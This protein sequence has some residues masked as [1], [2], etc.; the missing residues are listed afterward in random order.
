[1][2]PEPL[3]KVLRDGGITVSAEELLDVL[4]LAQRLPPS[5]AAPLARAARNAA[6][7]THAAT[8][9][10]K[11]DEGYRQQLSHQHTRAPRPS[12]AANRHAEN[13]G[14]DQTT[15]ASGRLGGS[16]RAD[17]GLHASETLGHQE[18]SPAIPLRVPEEKVLAQ[19]ELALSRALRPLKR[20][21]PD[22]RAW[23]LDERATVTAVAETGLLDPVMR[24]TRTRWL[25]L[26]M[27]I[28]DGVSMLLWRRLAT[29]VRQLLERSGAFRTV[30]VH[31]LDTRSRRAP[32]ISSRP[33][34]SDD[35]GAAPAVNASDAS[36]GSTLLLVMSDGVGTAW[37]DGRM[38]AVLARLAQQGPIA[39]MHTLPEHLRE[40]SGIHSRLWQVTTRRAGVA[41]R[42]W[43]ICDPVLPADLVPFNGLPV[44]VLEPSASLVEAWARLVGSSGATEELPLL[45]PVPPDLPASSLPES[46]DAGHDVLRFRAAVTPE[47][48]RLA[49]HVAAVAPVTVPVMRLIQKVLGDHVQTSHLAE[50]FLGGLIRRTD[51]GGEATHPEHRV[52]D[53]PEDTRRILLS[54][55]SASELLQ[56]SKA[57][58]SRLCELVGRAPGFAAW[59]AHDHGTG[60]VSAKGRP[61]TVADE[62][63]LQRLGLSVAPA[64][65]P[66]APPARG[67]TG[68]PEFINRADS[69]W[70]SLQ[71][72]DPSTLGP[73]T[74]FARSKTVHGFVVQY[75]AWSAPSDVQKGRITLLRVPCSGDIEIDRELVRTEAKALVRLI[76]LSAPTL[77][78]HGGDD[79][80][81]LAVE[82]YTNPASGQP[83]QDLATLL[84][85]NW[86]PGEAQLAWLGAK[87]AAGLARAHGKQ[88]I[89]GALTPDRVLLAEKEVLIT[90]WATA[91]IDSVASR[92]RATHSMGSA[93]L[94]PEL[95][96]TPAA[97]PTEASDVYALGVMLLAVQT[98]SVDAL[99]V[100][101]MQAIIPEVAADDLRRVLRQCVDHDPSARPSA[102]HV[103][104][105]FRAHLNSAAA[106]LAGSGIDSV[107]AGVRY[108]H[109]AEKAAP[110]TLL[111]S[112]VAR[113]RVWA[114]WIGWHLEAAGHSVV[115]DA[116]DFSSVNG[117]VKHMSLALETADAVV[118]V[119]S[120]SHLASAWNEFDRRI[121]REGRIVLLLIE[122][123]TSQ[124]IPESLTG[125]RWKELFNL[126]EPA[127]VAALLEAVDGSASPRKPPLPSQV[128]LPNVVSHRPPLPKDLSLPDIWNVGRPNPD[129]TGREAVLTRL[130]EVF[131]SEKRA[132]VQVLHG[133]A[134]VGK[135]Q[136][137]L[138]YARRFAGLYNL[139]WWV[140]AEDPARIPL[141]YAELG[142]RLGIDTA[143]KGGAERIETLFENLRTRDG[144]LFIIDGAEES[145]TINRWI[146]DG[147]GHVLITSRNPAWSGYAHQTHLGVF[148]RPESV[149]YL[150]TRLQVTSDQ[151]DLL[152]EDLGDHPLA[153]CQAVGVLAGGVTLP[154][155]RNLLKSSPARLL[156]QGVAPGYDV[157]LGSALSVAV[158][159]LRSDHPE[160]LALLRLTAFLGPGP[161]PATWVPGLLEQ[162]LSSA[163]EPDLMLDVRA[164]QPLARLGLADMDAE[165][166]RIHQLTQAL[167]RA[168]IDGEAVSHQVATFLAAVEL[169]RPDVPH[170]W[171]LW[172]L[173][174]AHLTAEHF[175]AAERPELR[176]RL[177]QAVE[178]LMASEQ[179][180]AVRTLV[181][182]LRRTWSEA[183]GADH[184]DCLRLST[185]LAVTLNYL[186]EHGEA[187]GIH[188]DNVA[189]HRR[190]LGDDHPDAIATVHNLALA[191]YRLGRAAE[192]IHLLQDARPRSRRV[193][194]PEHPITERL[195]KA[196][197]A[198]LNL[199]GRPY[200]AQKLLG[201]TTARGK[202]RRGRR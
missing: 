129:F 177:L 33:Y 97:E 88:I 111:I 108:P 82:P 58:N 24:P 23:E 8:V 178:Y 198:L 57:L 67:G 188:E 89:H 147:P 138:E 182:S 11:A 189:R 90:D 4:W 200:E 25:D 133:G 160:A 196:L 26:V 171:P 16:G 105:V 161:I 5:A 53:Y 46:Q 81:W 151:A 7:T 109:S 122:D 176:P 87:L 85:G 66:P 21:R 156:E 77:R 101:A 115:L 117:L 125:F 107:P 83:A 9:V 193:L 170:T 174:T 37:R 64:P 143:R 126:D 102:A 164:L 10:Q 140:D 136:I 84:R 15:R 92:H 63:L 56:T 166:F 100:N 27:L 48:Y 65:P 70:T 99:L 76:S 62:R 116:P 202:H 148:A 149:D 134:G 98:G 36:A 121:L 29:E 49:A 3:L 51:T 75:L 197:A 13:A 91:T 172:S 14:V 6:E 112:Y 142:S 192:A 35:R 52:F 44:P 104:R 190:V 30:R 127:A 183:I 20:S 19:E 78:R 146:P 194:G 199:Q 186:G 73:Y 42:T 93:L 124:D 163:S 162:Q 180:E 144:W 12:T 157:S 119:L 201:T 72:D 22:L 69:P 152:A 80:P 50:V 2:M 71:E 153:L 191:L 175:R 154:R 158:A 173:F 96:N 168:Q 40:S 135:T 103:S 118:V 54:T 59:L 169:G 165:T 39:V 61:F 110:K 1:M 32:Q 43:K 155:Y 113:D 95:R 86:L 185:V 106:Q 34:L 17:G 74:L 130:R 18:S 179:H 31:G 141:H 145:E 150:T 184:P 28:D 123:L 68:L 167:V 41:N 94:A 128:S 139:V 132:A 159:R 114:E 45:A 60:R 120:K 195:T 79:K 131:L 137:A 181:V 55:V 187:I 47:A 38:H